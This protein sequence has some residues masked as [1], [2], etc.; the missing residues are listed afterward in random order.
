MKDCIKLAINP[1]YIRLEWSPLRANKH[2]ALSTK[3]IQYNDKIHHLICSA[4]F[5]II[6]MSKYS[7]CVVLTSYTY[8]IFLAGDT[9]IICVV[10]AIYW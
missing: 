4:P 10:C 8:C 3:R 5:H 1:S 6:K 9:I 2:N 7:T